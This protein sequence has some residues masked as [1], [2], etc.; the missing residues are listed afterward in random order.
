M[1]ALQRRIERLIHPCLPVK[2]TATNGGSFYDGEYYLER[3]NWAN[4]TNCSRGH[5]QFSWDKDPSRQDVCLVCEREEQ[6]EE[7]QRQNK[8]LEIQKQLELEDAA[9]R[10]QQEL[11][12]AIRCKK[13]PLI[14]RLQSGQPVSL[15]CSIHLPV[16]SVVLEQPVTRT[17]S[18]EPLFSLGLIGW[19]VV[20]IVPQT[21]G[22][23]LQNTSYGSSVGTTWGAGLGGNVIGVHVML[24]KALSL[25]NVNDEDVTAVLMGQDPL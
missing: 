3:L 20:G 13:E 19:D 11:E 18:I 4:M 15:Y 21:M 25:G 17:F 5:E 24:R 12:E 7:R 1:E 6:F 10:K 23:A 14:K 22:V 2:L 9:R 16:N 8:A